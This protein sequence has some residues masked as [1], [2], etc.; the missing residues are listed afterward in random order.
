VDRPELFF[1]FTSFLYPATIY[2][3][4]VNTLKIEVFKKPSVD[5]DPSLYAAEQIFYF[6]KDGT[7]IPMFVVHRRGLELNGNNPVYLTG[8]GGFNISI[9]PAFSTSYLTWIEKGGVCAVPNLRGGGEYGREWHEAGMREHKQNVFDD[10]VA[11]A[12]RLIE[13]KYTSAGKI[14]ITGASNGGLLVGAVLTQHPELYGAAVAEVGVLDMLRFQ[15]FTIGW[16]WESDYGSSDTADGFKTLI[17]YSPLQNIVEGKCYPPTLVATGDHDDRV[18]P[19]H[20]FKFAA[21]LQ[22]AQGCDNPVLIRIASKAGHGS[23]KPITKVIDEQSD[24][25]AFMWNAVSGNRKLQS[26]PATTTAH[27][28]APSEKQVN[29]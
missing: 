29:R 16:A 20:S 3:Y 25:L 18:L 4:D 26:R 5:F 12:Q 13:L 24:A 11:A 10:F 27:G 17:K 21:A 1:A 6:S 14:A 2:R 19:G 28:D 15:K 9:T 22:A 23:G 7:R 8:Y